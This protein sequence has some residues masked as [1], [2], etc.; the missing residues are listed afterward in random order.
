[1]KTKKLTLAQKTL[2]GRTVVRVK[3]LPHRLILVLDDGVEFHINAYSSSVAGLDFA[4]DD[5]SSIDVQL[6]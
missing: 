5:D 6:G 2:I 3:H 4:V 1:M